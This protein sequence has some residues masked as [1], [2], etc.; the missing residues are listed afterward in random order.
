MLF[1]STNP[2]RL[3]LPYRLSR[4]I[5]KAANNLVAFR[6]VEPTVSDYRKDHESGSNP[7]PNGHTY[8]MY[9]DC[10]LQRPQGKIKEL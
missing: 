9:I 3:I 10:L 6:A 1:N 4:I 8:A 2:Y 7:K 5:I